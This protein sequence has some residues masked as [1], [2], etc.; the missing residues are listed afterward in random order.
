MFTGL[1]ETT[2]RVRSLERLGAQARLSLEIPFAGELEM[3]ESVAVNGCCLTVAAMDEQGAS[4]DLLAQTLAVTSLGDLEK[5]SIV[6]LERAL[7]VGDRFGG[8]FVQGHVDATGSVVA[9]EAQGQDHIFDVALPPEI[10]RLCIDKGSLCVDGISLTIAELSE[11]KARFWIT[12]HTFQATH[13]PALKAGARVNL[14]ADLLAK[15]VAKL[16]EGFSAARGA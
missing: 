12:P 2:G 1:V 10:E 13:L 11:G 7:Q 6:N 3:G 14:E 16:M 15:H 4:F 8:H 5:D 9:L